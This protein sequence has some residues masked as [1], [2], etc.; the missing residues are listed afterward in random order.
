M[1]QSSEE[2]RSLATIIIHTLIC[3][4][5]TVSSL[6][7]NS[8]VCL[9]F[10]RNRRLRTITNI[11][12]LS[13]AVTDIIGTTFAYP[14]NTVS[15]ALRKWPFSFTFC[16]FSGFITFLW[17]LVS[18]GILA[19]TAINR[20]VCVVKSKFYSTL[21]T[22]RKTVTSIIL[23]WLFTISFGL[24]AT[25]VTPVSFQWHT[26]YLFCQVTGIDVRKSNALV[27]SIV[28]VFFAPS[29]FIILFCYGSV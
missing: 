7:G 20:Y 14:F 29:M 16:Q 1:S 6:T 2:K 11:Y 3:F 9:A 10:H 5:T 13:L 27:F 15:S 25:F 18:V 21:F 8:L 4:L 17:A 12:V 19:L 23:V 26:Y 24:T 22:K 28:G